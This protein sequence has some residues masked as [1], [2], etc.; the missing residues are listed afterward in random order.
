MRRAR[1]GRMTRGRVD[2]ASLLERFLAKVN[3]SGPVPAHRPEL[4]ACHVWTGATYRSGYGSIKAAGSKTERAHRVAFFLNHGRWPRPCCLHKC[5]NRKCVRLEHLFEGTLSD[6]NADRDAK[7]RA[8]FSRGE[9]HGHAKLTKS[10]VA[11][12]LA[13]AASGESQRALARRFGCSQQNINKIVRRRTWN[14]L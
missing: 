3:V 7:G 10:H 6:N 1:M 11:A 12:V 14:H 5:D 4:G 9:S 8:I 13:A 2:V